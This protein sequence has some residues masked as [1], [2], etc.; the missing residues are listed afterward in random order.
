MKITTITIPLTSLPKMKNRLIESYISAFAPTAIVS[1]GKKLLRTDGV[2]SALKVKTEDYVF[3]VKGSV[4]SK[5][6]VTVKNINSAKISSS[7][8]CIY[9]EENTLCK[10]QVAALLYIDSGKPIL[11]FNEIT[12][13]EKKKRT[14]PKARIPKRSSNKDFVITNF[15]PITSELLESIDAERNNSFQEFYFVS[16][17][18]EA[19]KYKVGAKPEN[20]WEHSKFYDVT[21]KALN[22][23]DS[24]GVSCSCNRRVKKS[25]LCEHSLAL[26]DKFF[27]TDKQDYLRHLLP[28]AKLL[29]QKDIALAN[30]YSLEMVAKLIDY[31]IEELG[32]QIVKKE[33]FNGLI[34]GDEWSN[35]NI[36]S[37]LNKIDNTVHEE[38]FVSA[39]HQSNDFGFSII[40][41]L[42]NWNSID[43]IPL[44]AKTN[45][46]G[47]GLATLFKVY[48]TNFNEYTFPYEHEKE[49]PVLFKILEKFK[50]QNNL[51]VKGQLNSNDMFIMLKNIFEQSKQLPYNIY[52][53]TQSGHHKIPR[54][55]INE[56][57]LSDQRASVKFKVKK[58][59]IVYRIEVIVSVDEIDI[60]LNSENIK[61]Y[62][63]NKFLVKIDN[64]LHLFKSA[65]HQRILESFIEMPNIA[66]PLSDYDKL[67]AKFII[68]LL[69]NFDIDLSEVEN[70]TV[71]EDKVRPIA[72]QV[73]IKESDGHI[74]FVPKVVFDN[75]AV[76][77]LLSDE[78]YFEGE[79]GLE[80][81]DRD[82][83]FEENF[84]NIVESLHPSFIDQRELGVYFLDFNQ[85]IKD[86][87]FLD[88]FEMMKKQ[89]IKIFGLNELS[90]FKYSTHK[91][92]V[93]IG[94][95]SGQDWFD[96]D[97]QVSFGDY[98]LSIAELK[99]IA[100]ANDRYVELGDGSIGILPA[101]WMDKIQK[102]FYFSDTANNKG[103]KI[104]KMKF[105]L[106]DELFEEM[107]ETDIIEEIR[108][109]KEKLLS[110]KE[111][112]KVTVPKQIKAE[113]R[114]YQKEGLNWLNF[115]D[116]NSWGGILADDMGLGKTLQILT[117]LQY[118]I[119]I[120]KNSTHLIILPTTLV[121][122][123]EDEINKFTESTAV[124]FHI[125]TNRDRDTSKFAKS[126][127]II[128]TYGVLLNDIG[129]LKDF[130]F[131]YVILDESQSI[132]NPQSKRYKSAVLL[133]ARHKIALTGTPI[134]NNTFDLYAQM[135]F[136]N[137]GFLG[138][139]K[140]FKENYSLPIDRDRDEERARDLHKLIKPFLLR[141]TKEQ[142]ATDL[143]PKIEDI[144][145]CEMEPEQK[146]VY[147]AFR[148]KYRDF[149]MGKFDEQGLSKSKMYVLEG[150]TK[151]R[152]ICDSPMLLPGDEVYTNESA[153]IKL[154]L[155]H[156]EEKTNN[157]K[158]LVFSQFVKMLNLVKEELN[159]RNITYEYLD[160]KNSGKQRKESVANFQS[161]DNVRVFLISLKAG[162]TGLN[163]TAADYVYLLDPW[164][165]PAV[166][167][168]AIDRAYRIGQDK[169]VIAYRMI[170]KGTIEEK[171]MKIQSK[172][173]KISAD[174]IQTDD[175]VFKELSQND[176]MDLFN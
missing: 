70:I 157:H 58:E 136:V 127:I 26:F 20:F 159:L 41:D 1:R 7:C 38:N 114:P 57:E 172:K 32:I 121:F 79:S 18:H 83:E 63:T 89:G 66:V 130:E 54:R 15:S 37:I 94:I 69:E 4:K 149:L 21:I 174:I 3:K 78:R 84:K 110:F 40:F 85:M 97:M 116:D 27:H 43:V 10:H 72:K 107:N 132:K 88:A 108:I 139:Q 171:I 24:I 129:F 103:I 75:S 143:P 46:T 150:L 80:A 122:N 109:K 34:L 165:N 138:S 77:D 39:L 120:D 73:Y 55:N 133:N 134:E 126:N 124:H 71:R 142:V 28:G 123:W 112:S 51:K 14:T 167:N 62:Y 19:L 76:I 47:S 160:G 145:Y 152:Q 164:W 90:K 102:M 48:H 81:Y 119:N 173:K 67:Y 42:E 23:G 135:N 91:A 52:Y 29:I 151:L 33:E 111:I 60:V 35:R 98:N 50:I 99:K 105:S 49:Y 118:K 169:K 56:I 9:A 5:Y 146:K 87:W 53:F 161:N 16:Y 92:D 100:I 140:S 101:E 104:S 61:S 13:S 106:V 12:K 115:L 31:K 128:S 147:E 17:D 131:D 155:N 30:G 68:P 176:I 82:F 158:I 36:E 86:H 8:N 113:L 144:L 175:S 25:A 95:K 137:P 170:S 168:Q 96:V 148:N 93:N 125:G 64:S 166:E 117:L 163:L 162:G 11:D 154:L 153:K 65:K 59:T 44:T 74:M 6:S 2:L 22:G 156:I 141:R 45:K